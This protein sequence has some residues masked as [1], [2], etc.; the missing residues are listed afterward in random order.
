MP[1]FWYVT[2]SH[3]RCRKVRPRRWLPRGSG[4]FYVL[5]AR[6]KFAMSFRPYAG[7]C[8]VRRYPACRDGRGWE[9]EH[10]IEWKWPDMKKK[11]AK[12]S[13]DVKHLA[14][15]ESVRFSD[16]LPLVEHMAIRQYEDGDL[17]EPGWIT[18]KSSG[19]AWTVQVK[20]PDSCCSFAVVGET[21]DKALETAALLLGCDEAPW[22]QD[23]FLAQQKSS[24][25][26]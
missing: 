4:E 9:S 8:A 23:R 19:A 12:A 1:K 18:V 13:A 6:W 17:R 26:K 16:L 2:Y 11:S 7:I 20:D 24:R 25:K 14:A 22:E 5:T 10:T 3:R 15:L 21:L